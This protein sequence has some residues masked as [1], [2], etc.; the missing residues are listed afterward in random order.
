MFQCKTFS[1]YLGPT[2]EYE[3]S[4]REVKRGLDELWRLLSSQ[5]EM[6][7]ELHADVRHRYMAIL[8][9]LDRMKRADGHEDWRRRVRKCGGWGCFVHWFVYYVHYQEAVSLEGLTRSS[10]ERLQ[11]PPDCH[12]A[13]ILA[14][15]LNK[16]CGFG[17][18]LH[19][20]TYCLV[21]AAGTG[22]AL[23]LDSSGWSYNQK[24][25]FSEFFELLSSNW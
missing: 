3:T 8:A 4:R 25:G 20:A 7:E 2:L 24:G 1:N 19:H 5:L 23:S 6:E 9:D 21:V 11:N 17:C 18:Q 15:D 14:C 16:A 12:S 10:L 22:R 13:R